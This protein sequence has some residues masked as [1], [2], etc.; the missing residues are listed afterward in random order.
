[1]ELLSL[2]ELGGLLFDAL[3]LLDH[4]DHHQALL[5]VRVE[6]H[7]LLQV[8]LTQYVSTGVYEYLTPPAQNTR[9]VRE[10]VALHQLRR[11]L[12]SVVKLVGLEHALNLQ[13]DVLERSECVLKDVG[14]LGHGPVEVLLGDGLVNEFVCD[15]D[16]VQSALVFLVHRVF[17]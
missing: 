11:V 13:A 5:E 4:L 3:R 7:R 16:V 1:M 6:V 12:R 9:V 2:E 15:L 8:L 17:G 10:L 14:Q